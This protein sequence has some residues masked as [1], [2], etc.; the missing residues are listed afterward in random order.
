MLM[1]GLP[2]AL[3]PLEAN[4]ETHPGLHCR[5]SLVHPNEMREPVGD[6]QV[7][8]HDDAEV[9]RLCLEEVWEVRQAGFPHVADS[10]CS[11]GLEWRFHIEE[12]DIGL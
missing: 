5:M 6:P 3:F 10:I 2:S 12:N 9:P 11:F 7:A 4:G 8:T 1:H